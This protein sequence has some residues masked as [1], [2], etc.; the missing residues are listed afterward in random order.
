M[1]GQHIKENGT[2]SSGTKLQARMGSLAHRITLCG[3]RFG[4]G[5][6]DGRLKFLSGDVYITLFLFVVHLQRVMCLSAANAL[7]ASKVL[8]MLAMQYFSVTGQ[9]RYGLI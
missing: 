6:C 5:K 4:T 9:S 2:I 3:E 8:K 7:C 1:F